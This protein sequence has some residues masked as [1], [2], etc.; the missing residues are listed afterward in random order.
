MQLLTSA[1]MHPCGGFC[2]GKHGEAQEM[3]GEVWEAQLR[4]LSSTRT[5]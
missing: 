5:P 3:H 2:T 1:I 4:A